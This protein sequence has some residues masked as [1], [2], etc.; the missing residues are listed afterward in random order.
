MIDCLMCF[1]VE[2]GKQSGIGEREGTVNSASLPYSTV[3]HCPL[4]ES[5]ESDA[6]VSFLFC[7]KH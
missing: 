3:P 1:S 6:H 7:F 5:R 4:E 2:D